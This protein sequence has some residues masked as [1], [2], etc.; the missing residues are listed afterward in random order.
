MR[1]VGSF[2]P[3]DVVG[4]VVGWQSSYRI[5]ESFVKPGR[6][7]WQKRT[8]WGVVTQAYRANHVN[9]DLGLVIRLPTSHEEV[10][11][12]LSDVHTIMSAS[13]DHSHF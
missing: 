10:P 11:V 12:L 6:S 7:A 13:Y 9:G 2:D 3:K 4:R 1:G 5:D 8:D